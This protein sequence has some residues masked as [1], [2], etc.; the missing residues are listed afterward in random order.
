M[1]PT[2]VLSLANDFVRSQVDGKWDFELG[3]PERDL[4]RPIEWNVIVRWTPT[5]GSTLDTE[6]AIVVVHDLT[7]SVHFFER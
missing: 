5:D 4:R 1:N 2:D 6:P 3:T 7:G